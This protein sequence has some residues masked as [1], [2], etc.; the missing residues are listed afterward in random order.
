MNITFNRHHQRAQVPHPT[1]NPKA[2]AITDGV[3]K[4]LLKNVK[5]GDILKV[6]IIDILNK[7]ITGILP[8][9]TVFEAK[10]DQ[11]LEFYIGQQVAFKVK[12]ILGK[13]IH[14]ELAPQGEE[15]QQKSDVAINN[16]LK[17]LDIPVT[18][19]AQD[20]VK[21]LMQ[22]MLPV[23]KDSIKQIEFGLKSSQLPIDSLL[24]MLEN[25]IPI[26]PS[27]VKQMEGYKNGEIKL[28]GQLEVMMENIGASHD[29]EVLVETHKLL[30][31]AKE[32]I[33]QIGQHLSEQAEG[34]EQVP[35][36]ET[37][38]TNKQILSKDFDFSPETTGIKDIFELKTQ[39][40]TLFKETFFIDPAKLKDNSDPKLEKINELYKEVYKLADKLE[41]LEE[42]LPEE[43]KTQLYS[44]IKS[45]IEFLTIANKYDTMLHI[46][47]VIQDQ[48]KHGELYI[49]NKKKSDK[50]S[51]HEASM[52]ISLETVSLGTV[53]S[54]IKKYNKQISVQ[55]KTDD[56][57]I[58][59][60]LKNKIGLLKNSLKD[61]GYDLI[62]TSYIPSTQPFTVKEETASEKDPGR[63]RFDTKA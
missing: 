11:P 32:Q 49:F 63:Y 52:L 21:F 17:Q 4:L 43:Q 2:Q 31:S 24:T 61:K 7:Q 33:G 45:N 41:K 30:K 50:K 38:E 48:L 22:K 14:M 16:I 54:F 9:G 53:E 15:G 59:N 56:K 18:E 20:A 40:T 10:L 26:I 58:E 3:N 5:L 60:I 1:D 25:E 12:D 37:I 47:L 28:Q 57:L 62:S 27:T 51:Y 39:I 34:P 46:P 44:D 13:Q 55:F 35:G 23:T 29:V 6:E 42:K 36:K 8:D 19:D